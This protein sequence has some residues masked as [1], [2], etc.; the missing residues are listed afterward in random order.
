M[1]ICLGVEANAYSTFVN[2]YVVM[3]MQGY[4]IASLRDVNIII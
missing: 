1:L 4:L 3:L 2:V